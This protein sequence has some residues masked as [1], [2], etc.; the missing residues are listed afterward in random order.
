MA[1]NPQKLFQFLALFKIPYKYVEVPV[2]MPRPTL[3]E[4][5]ITYRRVPLLSIGSDM[6]IDTALII[7]KLSDIAQHFDC[8]LADSTNHI[9]Y[10]ALGQV[11]FRCAV[12][13][14]PLDTPFL[15]DPAFLADRSE[16]MGRP[17]NPTAM[18]QARPK[19]IS[20]MLSLVSLIQS[21]F[22]RDGRRFFL[23]GSTPTS[24][25]MY[26]YWSVNWG[27]RDR[28]GAR[29]EISESTYPQIFRWLADVETFIADR[30][31]E[32]KIQMAEAYK[33][34]RVPPTHEYAKFVPHIEVNPER[35]RQGQ[36]VE[37][38]PVDT[39]RTHPQAGELITLNYEQICLRNE[40]G[41]VMHFPRLGYEVVAA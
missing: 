4:I 30:R 32:T 34:L 35:L 16:L 24:A 36:R 20:K 37:V 41:L 1:P 3:A 11:A 7:E 38:T 22:L 40:K 5:G 19:T 15:K 8:G 10:D 31:V 33:V 26:L 29:P 25:D 23:G 28:E 6:Y 12:R 2:I 18:A 9:E 17:F 27:L 39:G 14:V 13:L 21:H